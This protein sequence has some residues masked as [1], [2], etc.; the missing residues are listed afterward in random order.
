[1]MLKENIRNLRKEKGMTQEALAEAMGVTTAAVSKWE[2]GQCVPDVELLLNLA[3]FFEV[4][5][6]TL[7]G[8]ELKADRNRTLLEEMESLALEQRF[9]EAKELAQ[10]LLRNYP[11]DYDVVSKAADLYYRSDVTVDG[12]SD[13]EYSIELTKRL[14]TL[15]DDPTGIE[16]FNLLS[17]LGNQYELLRNWEMARKYYQES[18]VFCANNR[19]LARMLADE[20]KYREA[21]DAITEEFTQ[22]LFNLLLNTMSLHKVWRELG[23]LQKAE[24]AL[25]WAIGM[26]KS[27]GRGIAASYGPMLVILYAQKLALAKERGDEAAAEACAEAAITLIEKKDENT[28]IDFLTENHKKLLVSSNLN[29]PD[30]IRQLLAQSATENAFVLTSSRT[31]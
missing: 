11:N 31:K 23:E 22:D 30:L 18:N 24:A 10:K 2:T 29:T 7:L 16:R 15:L 8:H 9:D 21:S 4:S 12:S 27:A 20:G 25:D 6:D 1:M 26:L 5:V 19:A 3:D 13:M 17:R 28:A 14:F